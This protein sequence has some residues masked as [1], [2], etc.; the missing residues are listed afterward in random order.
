MVLETEIDRRTVQFE[1]ILFFALQTSGQNEYTLY[2][3]INI[4]KA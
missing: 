4:E 3:T 2:K 1:D